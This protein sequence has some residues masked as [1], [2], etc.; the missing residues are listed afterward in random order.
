MNFL[1]PEIQHQYNKYKFS[2][3]LVEQLNQID[4]NDLISNSN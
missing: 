4:V 1:Y 2:G 3:S